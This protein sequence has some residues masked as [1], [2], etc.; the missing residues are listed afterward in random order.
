MEI[1]IDIGADT[2]H[3]LNKIAKMNSTE[4][5]VTA[6]EMLSFGA[7]I[8][9][10]SLE[11]KTDESTQLLLENSVRSVQIITEVLY[12]VYN[13]ELSKIGAYDAETA[14]AMI[15]RMLPNLLKSIS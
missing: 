3:S 9:L 11:K 2:L 6:A 15:E 12:S 13:K 5:N 10:Q 1:T 4:L 8:Y 14:L 7:R